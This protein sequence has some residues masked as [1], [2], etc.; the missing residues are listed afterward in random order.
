LV[1][2]TI[3]IMWDK[4][5]FLK[6]LKLLPGALV[7]VVISVILNQ[8]FIGAGSSLQIAQEHLVSLPIPETFD[9]FKNIIVTPDFSGFTN[10]AIWITA[11]T[12]TIVASVETLLCIEASD[13]MDVQKRYTDTNNELR[14]QG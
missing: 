1:S 11:A 7:A 14:A 2:L 3:L 10:P 6:N 13:R 5:P 8:I 9:D 4:I 12:I